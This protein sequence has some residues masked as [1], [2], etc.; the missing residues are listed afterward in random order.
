M[1]E[2]PSQLPDRKRSAPSK[3]KPI[4]KWRTGVGARMPAPKALQVR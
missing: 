1:T 4:P 3:Q 2:E